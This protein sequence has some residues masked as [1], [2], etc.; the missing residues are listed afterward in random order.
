MHQV[1]IF[2]FK[3]ESDILSEEMFMKGMKESPVSA[4]LSLGGTAGGFL[5]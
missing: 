1:L 5:M 4:L 2:E 3:C